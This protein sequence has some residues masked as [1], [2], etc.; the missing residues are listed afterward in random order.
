[1]AQAMS[2]QSDADTDRWLGLSF[3]GGQSRQALLNSPP[4]SG[5]HHEARPSAY[6]RPHP[7]A[8]DEANTDEMV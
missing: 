1:M 3:W 5:Y 7:G 4:G 2:A 8:V 6:I